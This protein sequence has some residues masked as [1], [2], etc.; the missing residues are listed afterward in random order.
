MYSSVKH[1][2]LTFYMKRDL[3]PN[4]IILLDIK[5]LI[6]YFS[7]DSFMLGVG[8][9]QCLRLKVPFVLIE[10]VIDVSLLFT[11]RKR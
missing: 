10:Y 9:G 3:I 8:V 5:Q 1:S 7:E 4:S 11:H 2:N 6:K